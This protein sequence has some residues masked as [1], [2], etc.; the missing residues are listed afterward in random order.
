LT[1]DPGD[2]WSPDWSPDDSQILFTSFRS[3]TGQIW[4]IPSAGGT[5][6][7]FT[8]EP[9]NGAGQGS[10]SPS[11][12]YICFR[13]RRNGSNNIWMKPVDGG[14]PIQVTDDRASDDCPVW[15]PDGTRIAFSS[16]RSGNWDIWVIDV[17]Y[18]GVRPVAQGT[19]WG[20]IKGMF[21]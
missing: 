11:G 1:F 14:D 8:D 20:R 15:S 3:G 18:A 10:W 4:I 19:T 5:A 13:S 16:L 7:Q 12:A 9:G 21:E 2:D 6:V 17:P